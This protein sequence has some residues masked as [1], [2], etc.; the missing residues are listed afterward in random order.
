[1]IYAR[2]IIRLVMVAA[3]VAALYVGIVQGEFGETM[4][5]ATLL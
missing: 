3:A 1:M 2:Y 5:N 4:F